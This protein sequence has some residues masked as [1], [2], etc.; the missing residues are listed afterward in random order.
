[1]SNPLRSGGNY[2][3]GYRENV[4]DLSNLGDNPYSDSLENPNPQLAHLQ[5][6]E[7]LQQQQR[8]QQE[9]LEPDA[10]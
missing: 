7:R 6:L 4:Y 10:G 8:E 2:E 5:E 3:D 9:Q 1:M